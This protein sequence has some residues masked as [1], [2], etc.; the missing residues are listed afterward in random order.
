MSRTLNPR[1]AITLVELL[2]VLVWTD[3]SFPL[4]AASRRGGLPEIGCLSPSQMR[5]KS[6]HNSV[7]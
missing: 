4:V 2:V 1:S 6:V 5:I 7:S 3:L